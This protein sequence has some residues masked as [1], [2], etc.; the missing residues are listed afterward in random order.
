MKKFN[1]FYHSSVVATIIVVVLLS[2]S[3]VAINHFEPKAIEQNLKSLDE[4][5]NILHVYDEVPTLNDNDIPPFLLFID[6]TVYRLNNILH[7][8]LVFIYAIANKGQGEIQKALPHFEYSRK[9]QTRINDLEGL[10]WDLQY[11][12]MIKF[13]LADY[14][15]ARENFEECYRIRKKIANK[16][17]L[18]EILFL[19]ISVYTILGLDKL[20]E[21]MFSELSEIHDEVES[22]I[23]Q[24]NFL[25]K[26]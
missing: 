23:V 11:I 6:H 25:L 14:A 5:R 1:K 26:P 21:N 8:L 22:S 4:F 7:R 13:E 24:N 12:G 2:G 17:Q 9:L 10:S 15:S 19:I 16:V 3:T 20:V 18:S